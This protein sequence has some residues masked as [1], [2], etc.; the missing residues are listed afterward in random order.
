MTVVKQLRHYASDHV[1]TSSR[2]LSLLVTSY[3]TQA[4]GS[5]RQVLF[6][7]L[8][9]LRLSPVATERLKTGAD[10]GETVTPGREN[11]HFRQRPDTLIPLVST[12]PEKKTKLAG[13]RDQMSFCGIG[14]SSDH[15]YENE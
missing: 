10:N 8:S 12:V 1:T 13:P 3:S 6:A 15:A 14:D 5:T 9:P 2:Y 4:H 11:E 7:F